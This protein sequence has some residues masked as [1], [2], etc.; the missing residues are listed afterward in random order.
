MKYIQKLLIIFFLLGLISF[1]YATDYYVSNSGNDNNSGTFTHPFLT[2]QHLLNIIQPGDTGYILHGTYHLNLVTHSSGTMAE[3]ITIKSYN[4]ESVLIQGTGNLSNGG[5]FRIHH[6]WYIIE[7]LTLLDGDAGFVLTNGASHN[8]IRNCTVHNCY[9]TGFYLAGGASYNHFIN[10]DA[11]DMYDSGTNGGNADGFGINGQ[12]SLPGEGNVFTACRSWN[13]SDDGFDVWKAGHPV[14]FVRCLSFNNG[15]HNG[16]GNGFKLGVNATQE[17]IHILKNCVAWNNRQNG[18]DYN[19]NAL[20]QI[21]YNC[22][23]YNNGRNYKFQAISG[24]P[25]SDDIQNC[26]SATPVHN[27]LLLQTIIDNNTNSWNLVNPNNQNIISDNFISTDDSVISGPRNPNGSIPE[28]D[29]LRLVHGSVFI[30]AGVDV[31]LAYNGNAPDLGAFESTNPLDI[32]DHF[33]HAFFIYPNPGNTTLHF[34]KENTFKYSIEIFNVLGKR[35]IK[36]EMNN[37]T[38]SI[39]ISSFPQGIYLIKI[40]TDKGSVEMIKWMKE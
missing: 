20:P 26:I 27:D 34:R 10:C 17:D 23:A 8:I 31:G 36:L 6:N 29:F 33:I 25:A 24:S 14:E 39:N 9:Y 30:D 35:M 3:P 37:T 16:D 40:T 38:Q 19:D 7:G 22:T 32:N 1:I 12:N 2:I 15:N 28:S 4:N 18:F 21:L 11:Y 5:R 13:N